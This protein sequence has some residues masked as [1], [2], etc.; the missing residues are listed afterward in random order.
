MCVKSESADFLEQT[1][2]QPFHLRR[3]VLHDH[4]MELHKQLC[5]GGRCKVNSPYI[6]ARLNV[7][8]TAAKLKLFI[9]Y[10][11]TTGVC[12]TK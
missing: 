5:Y 8:T 6:V 11:I 7:D 2:L 12:C 3:A 9:V 4:K 10:I 1:A